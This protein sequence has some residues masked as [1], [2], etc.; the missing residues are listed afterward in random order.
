MLVNVSSAGRD[1][2]TFDPNGVQ[3]RRISRSTI[4]IS[5]APVTRAVSW[6]CA[7][8]LTTKGAPGGIWNVATMTRS[9]LK[10]CAQARASAQGEEAQTRRAG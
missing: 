3:P 10:S 5:T 4:S 9:V 8:P 2:R 1:F 7:T 6:A